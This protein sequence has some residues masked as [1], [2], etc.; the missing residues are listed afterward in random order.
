MLESLGRTS[1]SGPHA[2]ESR[3]FS[4]IAIITLALGVAL[5]QQFSA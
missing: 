5:P 1:A 3:A 4:A 2:M